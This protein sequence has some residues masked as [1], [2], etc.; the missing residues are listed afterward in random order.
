MVYREE[1]Y[2][3]RYCSLLQVRM[4]TVG[5]NM[6]TVI[7]WMRRRRRKQRRNMKMD[8]YK[9]PCCPDYLPFLHSVPACIM[10]SSVLRKTT[11]TLNQ[12]DVYCLPSLFSLVFSLSLFS[13]H[14]PFP[15]SPFHS[16]PATLSFVRTTRTGTLSESL[17]RTKMMTTALLNPLT[18]TILPHR[19]ILPHSH[20]THILY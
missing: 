14:V 3:T 15:S 17:I 9:N 5:L 1:E 10:S 2:Q 18:V 6:L 13:L 16:H 11:N 20:S 12:C 19:A 4:M 7:A 8:R